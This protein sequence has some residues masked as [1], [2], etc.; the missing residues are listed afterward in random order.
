LIKIV[1]TVMNCS[2]VVIMLALIASAPTR[3]G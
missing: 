2:L 1:V 3:V